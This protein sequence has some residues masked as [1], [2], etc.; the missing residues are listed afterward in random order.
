MHHHS[1][2]L[3]AKCPPIAHHSVMGSMKAMKSM[4]AKKAGKMLTKQPDD[5]NEEHDDVDLGIESMSLEQKIDAFKEF[6]LSQSDDTAKGQF[7]KRYFKPHEMS[8]LWS[9]LKTM[10]KKA[11]PQIAEEWQ[12]LENLGHRAG[13]TDR[14][15]DFLAVAL[16]HPDSWESRVVSMSRSYEK[17][18]GRRK[19][20]RAMYWG[21]LVQAHGYSEAKAFIDKGKYEEF[22]DK[23]GDKY[24]KKIIIEEE[25]MEK[26]SIQLKGTKSNTVGEHD[27]EDFVEQFIGLMKRPAAAPRDN[28]E[29]DKQKGK[30]SGP[31]AHPPTPMKKKGI[32][33]GVSVLLGSPSKDDDNG[34]KKALKAIKADPSQVALQEARTH[35]Q[36]MI[37]MLSDTSTKLGSVLTKITGSSKLAKSVV[38]SLQSEQNTV[39]AARAALQKDLSSTS[40]TEKSL[41]KLMVAAASNIKTA[42]ELMRVAKPHAENK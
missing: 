1:S 23:D 25:E 31:K 30:D 11:S 14:K 10:R 6:C 3:R 33:R 2:N 19:L 41:K 18:I 27:Y 39:E 15:N 17:S 7:L 36:A 28:P 8:S 13:K 5:I 29:T 34:E 9:R 38:T 35:T 22:V 20:G 16:V 37:R 21:E 26:E 12:K 42:K 32:K 4:K 40:H 24:W